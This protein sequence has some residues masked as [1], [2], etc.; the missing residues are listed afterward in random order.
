[1]PTKSFYRVSEVA[2]LIDVPAST[3]RFWCNEFAQLAP[4]RTVSGQRLFTPKEIELCKR[5]KHLLRE[6]GLSVEFARKELDAVRKYPPR[7]KYACKSAKNAAKL[8]A[9]AAKYTTDPH[10]TARIDAVLQWLELVK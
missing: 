10:A 8:L 1:M 6:K 3:I 9:D 7:N 2:Q 5:I 4:K